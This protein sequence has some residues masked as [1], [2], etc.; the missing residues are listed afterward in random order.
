ITRYREIRA[1]RSE[2]T[3][4]IKEELLE[5]KKRYDDERRT[6]IIHSAEDFSVEDM[7]ADEDVVVTI[8]NKGYIK[9]MPLSGYRRQKRGGQGMKGTTTQDDEYVE[10]LFVATNHNYMLVVTEKGQCYWLKV[11]EIP[12][13][14]RLARGRAIVNLINLD[15][16]DAIKTFVPVETLDDEEYINNNYIMMATRE[17]KVKKTSLEAY[18][19]PRTNGII[20]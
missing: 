3:G 8:N 18:S 19:R 7:I 4:I 17:G 9:R 16:D 14:S 13:G 6:E 15:K 10:H 11:Y 2:Q 5:I 20:A 12:E 1:N